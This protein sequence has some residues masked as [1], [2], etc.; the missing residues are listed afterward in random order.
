MTISGN[1]KEIFNRL[2]EYHKKIFYYI[3]KYIKNEE[4]S[5]DLTHDVYMKA[6]QSILSS[7]REETDLKL[8]LKWLYI[9]ARNTALD[10][11]RRQKVESNIFINHNP[12]FEDLWPSR[13]NIEAK[14]I[15]NELKGHL[16]SSIDKLPT[17]IRNIFTDCEIDKKTKKQISKKYNVS[18]STIKRRVRYAKDVLQKELAVFVA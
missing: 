17:E 15:N 8:Y 13:E 10:F 12:D 9:I 6:Y 14:A 7:R 1:N 16:D 5:Y 3:S 4:T 18:E 2:Y 11:L